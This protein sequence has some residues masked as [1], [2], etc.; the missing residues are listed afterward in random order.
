MKLKRILKNGKYIYKNGRKI[1]GKI[2]Y[3]EHSK[4]YWL[5]I[6]QL[7]YQANTFEECESILLNHVSTL[8]QMFGGHILVVTID[9]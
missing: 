9:E 3:G 6:G 5:E 2:Y 7:G 8:P 1:E 4:T